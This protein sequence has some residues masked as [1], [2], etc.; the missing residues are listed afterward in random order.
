MCKCGY[1][2]IMLSLDMPQLWQLK[3]SEKTAMLRTYNNEVVGIRN[4]NPKKIGAFGAIDVQ[5]TEHALKEIDYCLHDLELDGL[6]IYTRIY[7]QELEEV[8][9]VS[10]LDKLRKSGVPIL[11]HPKDTTGIPIFNENYLDAVFFVAKMLYLDKYAY[12]K[13]TRYVLTHTGGLVDFLAKPLGMLYYLQ[14][15]KRKMVQFIWDW[16]ITKNEKG[17]AYLQS[18]HVED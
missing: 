3:D 18:V 14:L 17:Y 6:C 10:I 1:D 8:F 11:V 9:D 15:H 4:K 5:N 2:K 13:D 16:L 12:L 7:D